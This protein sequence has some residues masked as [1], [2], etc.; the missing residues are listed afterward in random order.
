M[1]SIR[2]R[3]PKAIAALG[4]MSIASMSGT[5]NAGNMQ[6]FGLLD[7]YVASFK[8]SGAAKSVFQLD[9]GGE[10]TPFWGIAGD[11]DLGGGFRSIFA[12]E[13]YFMVDTGGVGRNAT[14][15]FFGRAAYVGLSSDDYGALRF[16]RN[17]TPMFYIIGQFDPFAASTKLSPLTIQ[18]Y[19]PSFGRLIHGDTGW[20]NS[21]RYLSP[22][23]GGVSVQ[24]MYGLGEAATNNGT[25]NAG[26]IVRFQRSS[27]D[28]ALGAQ[29]VKVGPAV[30][31]AEPSQKTFFAGA[32]YDFKVT[33]VF[34]T[35]VQTRNDG[36]EL[37]THTYQIGASTPI[38][39]G[40]LNASYA[41]TKNDQR[42]AADF[43]RA[44]AAVGYSY[45]LSK[46]TDV[47]ANYLYDKLSNAGTG[48]TFGVGMRHKF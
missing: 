14:D 8:P 38:G 45:F 44:T 37:R 32:S 2:A 6:L 27:F 18:T 11:E 47:Y 10:A 48:N 43:R 25:N 9:N 41:W 26:A 20:S 19:S 39:A 42:V 23:F 33:K 24:L 1:K 46:R 17:S 13:S 7:T 40:K 31:A 35:Y 12:L 34:G 30:T 5:A 16:G 36:T 4:V 3:L 28:V 21:A 22:T 29:Q 15:S